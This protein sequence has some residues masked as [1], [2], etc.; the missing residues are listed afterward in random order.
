V[1]SA[2]LRLVSVLFIDLVGFTPLSEAREPEDVRELLGRCFE[3]AR[4]I[5]ERHGGVVEKFIGDAVVAVWGLAAAREDD[6]E[7]AVRAA[8]AVV[9]AVAVFGEQVDAVGLAARAGI[10]TGQA[11]ALDSPGE[12]LV[13][14]DRVNTASRVQ[15]LAAPGSVLVDETTTQLT[16]AAIAFEDTGEHLVKGK[17]QPLRL[18]RAARVI[19]GIGGSDREQGFQAPFVGRDGDLWLLK[20]LFHGALERRS[21]RL[22]A[23]SGEAGVG[24][25]RLRREFF[26]YVDGLSETVLWHFGH[27]VSFGDGVAYWALGEMVRQR[28]GIA[29]DTPAPDAALK[30]AE[31]L[32]RW[33]GDSADREFL[34]PRLGALLG[35]DEPG[36]ARDELFSGWRLF[37]ERLAERLPVVLVFEDLQWADAGLLDFIGQLLDWSASRPIFILTLG[38]PDADADRSIWT[39]GRPGAV[40]LP[41]APLGEP[42]MRALLAGL[43][44]GLPDRVAARIMERAQGVPLY[45]V[46]IVRALADRG[47]FVERGGRLVLDGEVGAL[48]VPASLS[49]LLAARLDALE[50]VERGFV[51]AMS[52]LGGSF[53]RSTAAALGGV[54]ESHLDAVLASLVR[55]QV[56]VIRADRLSP[57][58]G[59]YTF[60]QGL[61]RAVAYEMLSRRERAP[62]HLAAAEHLRRS[63]PNDGEDVAEVIASHYLDAYRAAGQDREAAELRSKA[64]AALRRAARRAATVGAPEAAERAYLAARELA[65]GEAEHTELTQAAGEMAL[66]SGHFGSAV[67]LLEAAVGAHRAAGRKR[68]AARV[69]GD[70]GLALDRLGSLQEAVERLSAAV[71]VLGGDRL[72]PDVARLN[73]RL[74]HALVFL[75][76]YDRAEPPLDAALATAEALDLPAVLGDALSNKA[77]IYKRTGRP[78]QARALWTAATEIDERHHL[79]AQLALV[80][81][82]LGNQSVLWDAADAE[83]QTRAGLALAR[84][85]GDRTAESLNA[86]NLMMVLLLGGRWTEVEELAGEL[87]G[88]NE[89]RPAATALHFVLAILQILRGELPAARVSLERMGALEHTEQEERRACHAAIT[90]SLRLAEGQPEPA[91]E[92]GELML[93]HV[94][95]TLGINHESVRQAWPDTVQAAL[96]LGRHDDAQKMLALLTDQPPGNVSPF[97]GAQLVRGRALLEA[98]RGCHEGVETGLATAIEGFRKLSY[99]YWVAVTQTEL[100]TW[101]AGHDRA[102]EAGALTV[103][104]IETLESLRAEPALLRAQ[105]LHG[106]GGRSM[107]DLVQVPRPDVHDSV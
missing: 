102:S 81:T 14:G 43:V 13:V 32:E 58:R 31:G 50:P 97:L 16:G 27:C 95:D 91:F 68:D 23:V 64:L 63:F 18:W 100:A 24:K 15:A 48:D 85:R 66:Q 86:A 4:T 80:R 71:R 19:A 96:A 26:N 41:L 36:L 12:G 42:A 45:A 98:A 69:A 82:N 78:Q 30:L 99:P 35:V 10:V 60:A 17:A 76:D 104:A 89:T 8:L 54:E 107:T 62:R 70:L 25:S 22:V 21:A 38:R 40:A 67:E 51:K 29:E 94:I 73:V 3:T 106:V 49:S 11:A 93:G 75:G 33:V 47:V 39:A 87:L 55:K 44:D 37:F 9:E 7:R 34:K 59:Q 79:G 74:G 105:Q 77:I 46:E 61:L 28:F 88:D 92:R 57:E 20:E 5:I 2:E 6:A 90:A 53:A 52:V 1:T 56:L 84:R 72:D 65:D 83:E 101:L 103:E